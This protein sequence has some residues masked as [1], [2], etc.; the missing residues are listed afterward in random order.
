MITKTEQLK[1]IQI[2]KDGP[3]SWGI[4]VVIL[5]DGNEISRTCKRTS[6]VPTHGEYEDDVPLTELPSLVQ[7]AVSETWTE[8][9]IADYK[10]K[11]EIPSEEPTEE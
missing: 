10:A 1:D 11:Q 9:L 8:E 4:D 7:Q 6:I 3:I 5:E 2:S